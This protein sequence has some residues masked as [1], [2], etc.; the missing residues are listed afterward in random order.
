[1]INQF[2]RQKRTWSERLRFLLH[3]FLQLKGFLYNNYNG[4]FVNLQKLRQGFR[5]YYTTGV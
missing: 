2:S 3:F 4:Y 5:T 1:V